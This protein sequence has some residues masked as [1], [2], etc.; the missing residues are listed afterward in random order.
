MGRCHEEWLLQ[1]FVYMVPNFAEGEDAP[2]QRSYRGD[3]FQFTK[4]RQDLLDRLGVELRGSITARKTEAQAEKRKSGGKTDEKPTAANK[5]QRINHA[6][7]K[8]IIAE[9]EKQENLSLHIDGTSG[10]RSLKWLDDAS[11]TIWS[12]LQ[13]VKRAAI[14]MPLLRDRMSAALEFCFYGSTTIDGTEYSA[15]SKLRVKLREAVVAAHL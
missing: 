6:K 13:G 15:Y 12:P 11:L 7:A 1:A 9:I 2:L 8:T 4:A 10:Q 3:K 5:R 14:K